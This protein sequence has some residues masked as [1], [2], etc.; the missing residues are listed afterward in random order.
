MQANIQDQTLISFQHL[1][2]VL[3]K[4]ILKKTLKL[5]KKIQKVKFRLAQI[6]ANT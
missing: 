1:V 3:N 2:R 6:S 5:K 4:D